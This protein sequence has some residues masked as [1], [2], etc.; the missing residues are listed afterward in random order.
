MDREKEL[1]LL[2]AAIKDGAVNGDKAALDKA[3]NDAHDFVRK[4]TTLYNMEEMSQLIQNAMKPTEKICDAEHCW[5]I[6]RAPGSWTNLLE[7]SLEALTQFNKTTADIV[8]VGTRDS[9]CSWSEFEIIAKQ[10]CFYSG[11]GG[12]EVNGELVIVGKDWWM[13]REEYDGSEW[14][15]F[16]QMPAMP[17]KEGI[18]KQMICD[19]KYCCDSKF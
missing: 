16:C 5:E 10:F 6:E 11:F 14:W 13:E 15:R 3:L 17:E 4:Q 18:T 9:R 8:W 1:R 12:Q 7:D 2:I 19:C